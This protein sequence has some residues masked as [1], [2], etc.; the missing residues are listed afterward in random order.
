V[1]KCAAAAP[2]RSFSL[3]STSGTLAFP[4]RF[5][6]HMLATGDV[7]TLELPLAF[8]V[9]GAPA[10]VPVVLTTG[11]AAGGSVMVEGSPIGADGSVTFVGVATTDALPSP[12]VLRLHCQATP[13]PD[14]DQFASPAET[15]K[16]AGAVT[17]EQTRLRARFQL[18]AAEPAFAEPVLIRLAAG[19]T[20]V[21]TLDL[22]TGLE[23]HGRNRFTDAQGTVTVR[24]VRRR[25]VATYVLTARLPT[26]SMPPPGGTRVDVALT[27]DVGGLLSRGTRVFHSNR[28]GTRLNAP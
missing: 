13:A 20:T 28:R 8:V 27:Y 21:A 14:L 15:M 6:A 12:L 5:E 3:G 11:L 9:D 7:T 1:G 24:M 23:P 25:P 2:P 26:T 22:P 4:P 16:I 18:G 19:D 17:T 10:S